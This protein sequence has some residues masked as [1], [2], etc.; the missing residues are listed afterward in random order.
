MQYLIAVARSILSFSDIRN[1]KN[2]LIVGL[3]ITYNNYTHAYV[4]RIQIPLVPV[5]NCGVNANRLP[6]ALIIYAAVVF[7]V[8]EY[9]FAGITRDAI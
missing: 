6:V 5:T 8:G 1:A 9:G 3:F 7:V 2:S 4:R